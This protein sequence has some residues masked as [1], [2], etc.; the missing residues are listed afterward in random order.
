[1]LLADLWESNDQV[2]GV[3]G[4]TIFYNPLEPR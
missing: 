2:K 1:M 3:K 4:A